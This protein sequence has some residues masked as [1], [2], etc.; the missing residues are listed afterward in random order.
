ME[1]YS[2]PAWPSTP[3]RVCVSRDKRCTSE[4]GGW[5]MGPACI[6]YC[7]IH[8]EAMHFHAVEQLEVLDIPSWFNRR[9]FQAQGKTGS[10]CK[11]IK[12]CGGMRGVLLMWSS[13]CCCLF[14][15]LSFCCRWSRKDRSWWSCFLTFLALWTTKWQGKRTLVE[16][17]AG[18][19]FSRCYGKGR[20]TT[21]G[22]ANIIKK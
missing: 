19:L 14:T 15:V 12:S 16:A 4:V 13:V 20:G 17:K 18:R 21:K 8:R 10:H 7:F 1:K 6:V 9:V 2:P 3:Q 5:A 22:S 11:I